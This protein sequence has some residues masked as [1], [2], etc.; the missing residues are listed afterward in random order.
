MALFRINLRDEP[1]VVLDDVAAAERPFEPTPVT[2]DNAAEANR[3][4]ASK[5]AR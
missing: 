3:R 1:L 5:L 2:A 4:I